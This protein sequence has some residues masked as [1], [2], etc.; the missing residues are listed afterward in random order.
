MVTFIFSRLYESVGLASAASL[1][2]FIVVFV[3]TI[4]RL[5][6]VKSD[7]EAS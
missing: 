2:L 3:V 1:I 6:L 5:K 4:A 7:Y